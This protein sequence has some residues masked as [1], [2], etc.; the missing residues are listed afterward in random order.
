MNTEPF[1]KKCA[2]PVA[3]MRKSAPTTAKR[4]RNRA[5]RGIRAGVDVNALIFR[6]RALVDFRAAIFHNSSVFGQFF[7]DKCS[8][9]LGRTGRWLS[10]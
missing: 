1:S 9:F 8:K 6:R 3:N 4:A 5:A 7:A 2:A 10:A